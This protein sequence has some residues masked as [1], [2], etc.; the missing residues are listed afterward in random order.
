MAER[1]DGSQSPCGTFR[2]SDLAVKPQKESINT[3][4]HI[5][6]FFF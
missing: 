2:P 5:D 1:R 4:T 6:A 3:Q